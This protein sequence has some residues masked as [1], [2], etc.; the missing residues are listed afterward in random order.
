MNN[1]YWNHESWGS[2]VPPENA[3]EIIFKANDKIDEFIERE[4]LDPWDSDEDEDIVR[5]FCE[6]LW[7]HY[8]E[9]EDIL[10]WPEYESCS[11]DE[12]FETDDA[13]EDSLPEAYRSDEKALMKFV[14]FREGEFYRI[15]RST[16][17]SPARDT[18]YRFS[19][20]GE[21]DW[22]SFDPIEKEN[23]IYCGREPGQALI[24][25]RWCDPAKIMATTHDYKWLRYAMQ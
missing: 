5:D 4:G 15:K 18:R 9:A 17:A 16:S 13:D 8:C 25:G 11:L 24:D 23:A 19:A 7:E 1:Y 12:C 20:V 21:I 22:A 10:S 2:D 14:A 3:D 6:S